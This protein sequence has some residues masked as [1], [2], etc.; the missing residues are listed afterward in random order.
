MIFVNHFLKETLK[1]L[2][3]QEC[4]QVFFNRHPKG[5]FANLLD[6]MWKILHQ[7]V[8]LGKNE[9]EYITKTK[10]YILATIKIWIVHNNSP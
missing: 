9:I 8:Q 2:E 3:I 4:C 7:L 10:N 6:K 5:N 1:I